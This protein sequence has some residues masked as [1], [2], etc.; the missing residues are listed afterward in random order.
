MLCAVGDWCL[1]ACAELDRELRAFMDAS[2]S[3]STD[4]DAPKRVRLALDGLDRLDTAGAWLLARTLREMREAEMEVEIIDA[5][6]EHRALIDLVTGA[7]PHKPHPEL[8]INSFRRIVEELGAGLIVALR[9][10]FE[11]I[12]FF[13]ALVSSLLVNLFRPQNWRFTSIVTHIE[14]TGVKAVPIVTLMSFLIGIVLAYQGSSQLTQF[15]A[16]IFTVNLLAVSVLRE[17][18]ILMTAIIVAGRSGSAFTAQIG[19]M[20]VNEEIDA[21]RVIG[22]EPLEVLVTPRV[23]ALLIALPLLCFLSVVTSLVGGA[24]VVILALDI[25]TAQF[26][27]Q[28]RSAAGIDTFLVGFVKAPVFAFLIAMVGCYEGLRVENNAE[29]V[30]TQTTKAV[31]V[32]IF[33]VIIVDAI[34]SILFSILGI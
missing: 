26:L 25:P 34:F 33:L 21:M 27:Q 4:A 9:E 23:V 20:K 13:G 10:A 22:L 3:G 6:E 32:T 31:V 8:R 2:S 16:E 30:G 17:L 11:L 5:D 15:G 28:L 1:P 18:G 19:M 24:L 12:S 29:S 7:D 14:E